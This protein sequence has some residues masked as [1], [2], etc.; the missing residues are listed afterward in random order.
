MKNGL[1]I[2]D[3]AFMRQDG[4]KCYSKLLYMYFLTC[5]LSNV[6]GVYEIGDERIKSDLNLWN[7]ELKQGLAELK[8][9]KKVRRCGR[10]VI[11]QDAIHY[12]KQDA[13]TFKEIDKII[14]SLPEKIR[15]RLPKKAVAVIEEYK[16]KQEEKRL[17]RIAK[18][19]QKASNIGKMI[20]DSCVDII[21]VEKTKRE[22]LCKADTPLF[23]SIDVLKIS[24]KIQKEEPCQ[25]QDFDSFSVQPSKES[26]NAC[27]SEQEQDLQES[28]SV[29]K[30]NSSRNAFDK[31]EE[32]AVSRY[33][34]KRGDEVEKKQ[35]SDDDNFFKCDVAP[36]DV[37][38]KKMENALKRKRKNEMPDEVMFPLLKEKLAP[39]YANL[40]DV[41]FMPKGEIVTL[42][43][44]ALV[45]FMQEN[46]IKAEPLNT[47]F[48]NMREFKRQ[49][50]HFSE[51]EDV[52][53]EREDILLQSNNF[54]ESEDIAKERKE[55]VEKSVSFYDNEE[56]IRIRNDK[57]FLNI[58]NDYD[59]EELA[60]F[61]FGEKKRK[62]MS[63]KEEQT[64]MKDTRII[65]TK[66]EF[67][68]YIKNL[69]EKVL[70]ESEME[71][72]KDMPVIKKVWS[73]Y[74][75]R[76]R[77]ESLPFEDFCEQFESAKKKFLLFDVDIMDAK[78]LDALLYKLDR[79]INRCNGSLTSKV[80][81]ITLA[82]RYT[83]YEASLNKC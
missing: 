72:E 70:T 26:L 48:L 67:D 22:E 78:Q 49:A 68:E 44:N 2:W 9:L 51:S 30:A 6:L 11:I 75:K 38:I 25:W 7:D 58:R 32:V 17:A 19:I 20:N 29:K 57:D 8:E 13:K 36:S 14:A 50:L 76:G 56:N 65:L 33:L 34:N 81:F 69:N 43:H 63:K 35:N 41:D 18:K 80:P 12:I 54:V 15:E 71:I 21:D 74:R 23:D 45:D 10:F 46:N 53:K 3:S 31:G 61:G 47:S 73:F 5:P 27:S 28:E 62:T 55:L 1:S 59:S 83:F 52:K 39:I 64:L 77:Y 16:R 42:A 37:S 40:K 82:E 66:N 60:E 4:F 24:S 79:Y